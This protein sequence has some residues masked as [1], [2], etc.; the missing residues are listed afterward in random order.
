MKHNTTPGPKADFA[1]PKS[2]DEEKKPFFE[3]K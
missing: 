1:S 2:E 3:N